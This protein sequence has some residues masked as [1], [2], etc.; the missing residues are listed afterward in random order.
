MADTNRLSDRVTSY[1]VFE[2][3]Q[4]LTSEQLN[5]LT[6][7]L[8]QQQRMTRAWL[9]G[10]GVVCGL[11]VQ[12]TAAQVSLSKGAALTS[13]GD[14]L[15]FD[16][17]QLFTQ[18]KKFSDEDAKYAPF[19]PD[20]KLLPLFELVEKD[21]APLSG[22]AAETG[23][24]LSKMVLVLY[25]ESYLFDPDLCTGKGCDNLGKEARNNLRVL[26]VDAENAAPLLG[27]QALLARRYPLL[28]AYRLP[29]VILDPDQLDDFTDLGS[30]YRNLIVK[31]I[32]KLKGHL[33]QTWQP[34][35]RPLLLDL[36]GKS[37]PT[38]AW[39]QIL[40]GW[41][42]QVQN[43][44]FGVQ[45]LYDFL[46][47]LAQAY[48]D[49]KEALFADNVLCMPPVELFPKHV[50]LGG[51]SE[52]S[53]LRHGFYES[54]RLNQKDRA[55]VKVR[56]LH[57]RLDRMIRLFQ[58]PQVTSTI[59]ITPSR[60]KCVGLGGRAVP[61]YYAPDKLRP[62]TANWCF[63]TSRR[64]LQNGIYC[65]HAAELG[66]TPEAKAPLA[67]DFDGCDFF[68][69]EGHLGG[70]VDS[71]ESELK[72]QIEDYN[73]PLQVLTLQIE[74]ALPPLKIR[75]L[76][77]LRDLK[78]LHRFHRQDLLE[79]LGNIK[80]FTNR[81]KDT[82]KQAA[83]DEK[84]PARDV[85]AN[86]LNY[87]AVIDD[88]VKDLELAIGKVSDNLKVGYSQFK[89]ADFRLNYESAVQKTAGINKNVRGVTYT[90]A[91]TPYEGLLN[92]SKFKWLGWIEEILGKRRQRAE[93]LSVFARFLK[94]APAMEHLAGAPLGGTFVL[95]YS[96]STKKIVAD[97]CLPYW[98]VDIPEADEPEEQA[99]PDNELDW[100]R[101]NDFLFKRTDVAELTDAFN[102]V[103]SKVDTFD[104]RL[105]TQ[106]TIA[107]SI[108]NKGV[109]V[110]A[111]AAGMFQDEALGAR[112]G[113]LEQ[114]GKYLDMINRRQQEGTV[115]PAEEA[116]RKQ[117]EEVSGAIIRDGVKGMQESGR[118]ILPGSEQEVFM[119]KAI[120]TS[121]RM[122]ETQ[123]QALSEKLVEVQNKAGSKPR[124]KNLLNEMIVK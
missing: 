74:T 76:G 7:Y 71:V 107:D 117:V 63:A 93:E 5:Q 118:D 109:D 101:W 113:M 32:P 111:G 75:P 12:M 19:R 116:V 115:T 88:D 121:V 3:N 79:N 66:G 92:D 55:I 61:Y 53:E 45:Y 34:L 52:L 46:R 108:L 120:E 41:Q 103:K 6:S 110:K 83:E 80:I 84:L 97:F 100:T 98:H 29:R 42:N 114:M 122:G 4:V 25:L 78:A 57:Q 62:L 16:Q 96:G 48:A 27:D 106:E 67:Y 60:S 72:K 39:G 123:K 65:Y 35:I 15:A 56:F 104:W 91:F 22:F 82:F 40:D 44:L 59:R 1:T 85:H 112:A 24:E 81:V 119:K 36:Y 58:I 68:R 77:P 37:D 18:F 14:L 51:A 10:V 105:R 99:V 124:M 9:H 26:L 23:R 70:E 73:L 54:P 90:S 2:E 21:G 30:R 8:D 11:Q 17:E 31:A 89:F 49:F 13:D 64:G 20:A 43:S 69:I 38:Q 102:S 95:V 94:E 87:K 47:D 33:Q 50:L 28:E 86:T